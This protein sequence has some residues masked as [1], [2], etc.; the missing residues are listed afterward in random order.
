MEI[1]CIEKFILSAVLCFF[2][3]GLSF[4]QSDWFMAQTRKADAKSVLATSELVEAQFAGKYLYPPINVL[5]GDFAT[6]W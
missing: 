3:A 1:R 2:A 5:D 4:D 6:V